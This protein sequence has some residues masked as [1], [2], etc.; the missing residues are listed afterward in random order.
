MFF[1]RYRTQLKKLEPDIS[2]VPLLMQ[3]FEAVGANL[4]N[5]EKIITANFDENRLG[6]WLSIMYS[7]KKGLEL[8]KKAKLRIGHYVFVVG[9]DVP[10]RN[11]EKL[12]RS[13][14][15]AHGITGVWLIHTLKKDLGSYC[16][17]ETKEFSQQVVFNEEYNQ[18]KHIENVSSITKRPSSMYPLS[19]RIFQAIKQEPDKIILAGQ[20]FTGKREA[21]F[22]FCSALSQFPPLVLRLR[23]G[24][25]IGAFADMLNPVV[26]S[27]ICNTDKEKLEEIDS[28][29]ASIFRERLRSEYSSNMIRII[30]RFLSMVL[31]AY[32]TEIRLRNALPILVIENIQNADETTFRIFMDAWTALPAKGYFKIY[33]TYVGNVQNRLKLWEEVFHRVIEIPAKPMGES[34]NEGDIP[35]ELWEMTYL[36]EVLL[37]F[38]PGYMLPRLMGEVISN[39]VFGMLIRL[40]IVDF[41]DDP[42]PRLPNFT[43]KAERI[44]G[45]RKKRVFDF[46]ADCL[47]Q[48]VASE[49]ISTC[50]DFVEYLHRLDKDISDIVVWNAIRADVLNGTCKKIE[51]AISG[52]SLGR[53]V[54]SR[55]A[56]ILRYLFHSFSVL[57]SGDVDAVK[58]AFAEDAP[59]PVSDVYRIQLLLNKACFALGERRE[60]EAFETLKKI[61]NMG[62]KQNGSCPA[63]TYR[64]ISIVNIQSRKLSEAADYA[65]IA[66]SFVETSGENDELGVSLFYAANI[67]YLFGNISKAERL[68]ASAERSAASVGCYQWAQRAR[69]LS[70]KIRFEFG[71]YEKAAKIFDS[72]RKTVETNEAKNTVDAWLFRVK[73]FVGETVEQRISYANPSLD[74]LLFDAEVS[75][76]TGKYKET[77][78]LT[79]KLLERAPGDGYLWTE[80]PDWASGF[81]Q[82]EFLLTPEQDFWKQMALIYHSLSLCALA[83]NEK[84]RKQAI[85]DLEWLSPNTLPD[86]FPNDFF[87][88]YALYRVLRESGEDPLYVNT[89]VGIAF[90]R[91]QQRGIKIDAP[92]SRRTFFNR[93]YWNNALTAAAKE[94]KLI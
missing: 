38:F 92:E 20:P 1:L 93:P 71:D 52:G 23:K 55:R 8:V 70:G 94:Y 13:L 4:V 34:F 36:I 64:L 46:A 42:G 91:L 15:S 43:A 62:K 37:M 85:I 33:G 3:A 9:K 65:N 17:F 35:N 63:R 73:F 58:R 30:G 49:Q 57:T 69:F 66:A 31:V 83:D 22:R 28:L 6:I 88:F 81:S 56:D 90:K 19:D 77:M 79:E 7:L 44:I 21:L 60:E 74:A 87:Y 16:Q 2:V 82:C 41:V 26:R 14:A 12:C 80:R 5:K 48:A 18:I 67:Q 61:L 47:S 51:T 53:I 40:G 11:E 39:R 32:V 27:F 10:V 89:V 84:A 72:L 45:E 50:F 25:N 29:Q 68:A 54:G 76:I 78:A 86:I 75:Y 59:E 24:T